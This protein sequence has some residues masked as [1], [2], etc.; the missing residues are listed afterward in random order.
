MFMNKGIFDEIF[1]GILSYFGAH[2]P[3]SPM[4]VDKSDL[5]HGYYENSTITFGQGMVKTRVLVVVA[6]VAYFDDKK[7]VVCEI[8]TRNSLDHKVQRFSFN[9][10][11]F[12]PTPDLEFGVDSK[13][14]SNL[15]SNIQ[16][17]IDLEFNKLAGEWQAVKG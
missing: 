16:G 5:L 2:Y 8:Q 14:F 1:K 15:I 12:F 17:W 10:K 3:N 9:S 6:M 7:G 13:E 4:H 11:Q